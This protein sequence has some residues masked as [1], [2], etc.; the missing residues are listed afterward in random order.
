MQNCRVACIGPA[1]ENLSLISGIVHDGGRIAARSGLGAVMG[2]KR[3][4]ALVLDGAVRIPVHNRK[5]V[6]SLT[7][8]CNEAVAFQLPFVPGKMTPHL[9]A[10]MRVL[11]TQLATDGILYKIM[12]RKW[13]TVSMNQMSIEMG[14]APIKNCKGSNEDFARR[15]RLPSVRPPLLII[16][17]SN[18]IVMHALWAVAV[19]VA[20]MEPRKPIGLNMKQFWL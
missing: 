3:L 18:I 16:P 11:P 10:L 13:G 2:A 12:L 8:A 9:G 19:S 1:G 15:C 7:K 17:L 5:K 14:D 20:R 6:R 4:K